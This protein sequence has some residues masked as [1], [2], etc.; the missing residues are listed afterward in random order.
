MSVEVK[1]G[2][3]DSPRELTI[4]SD[5]TSEKAY[6]AVEAALGGSQQLLSLV[7]EKGARY[8]VPVTKIAY[9]EVGASENRKVGFGS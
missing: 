4:T 3:T 8:I 6:A 9:V 2:I 7:D 1:I 5:L